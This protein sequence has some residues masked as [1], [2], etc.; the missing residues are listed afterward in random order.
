VRQNHAACRAF[1]GAFRDAIQKRQT[2]VGRTIAIP[3]AAHQAARIPEIRSS[4]PAID[5]HRFQLNGKV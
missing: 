2:P 3:A 1:G 5:V 4:T